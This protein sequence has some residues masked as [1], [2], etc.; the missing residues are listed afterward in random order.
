M[1]GRLSRAARL[2]GAGALLA[3][4]AACGRGPGR[5]EAAR[6]TGGDPA[7][8][9]ELI[10]HYGCASCHTIAGIPGANSLVG[11]PLTGI[12]RR[13]YIAGVLT[14][15]PENLARWIQDP[16]AVDS[17]TAMPTLGVTPAEARDI[18]AY[19]YSLR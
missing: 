19:L 16:K 4:L 6:L 13:V 9:G 1:R 18:V 11:P 8:G 12:L 7:R 2:A 14:N 15:T 3:L 17:L 5:T 10:R